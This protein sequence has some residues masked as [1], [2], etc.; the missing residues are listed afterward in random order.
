MNEDISGF[1]TS[2][3]KC[4][5]EMAHRIEVLEED[6]RYLSNRLNY[7]VDWHPEIIDGHD[8]RLNRSVGKE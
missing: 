7:H 5:R 3:E 6:V 2:M 4:M 1:K 8:E